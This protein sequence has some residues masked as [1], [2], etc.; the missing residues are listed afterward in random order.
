MEGFAKEVCKRLPLAESVLRL[1][2]FVMEEDFVNDV[3]QRHRGRSYEGVISFPL[4]VNLTADALLQY[5][6]SG[7]RSFRKAQ[8]NEELEASIEAMYGKLRR[9]S[10]TLSEGFFA[11]ATRRL[12]E[13]FPVA[14]NPLPKSLRDLELT[15]IDGKK[16]KHVAKRMK[17]LRTVKGHVLGGKTVVALSLRTNLAVGLAADP[18]GEVSDAPLVP[19]L[20]AQV[21][22]TSD[23][24]RL[25]IADRQFCDLNQPQLFSAEGDHFLIRYNA[26]LKFHRDHKRRI[27]PGQD[28][29][30]RT[31]KEEWGWLGSASDKRRRYVRRITLKRKDAEDV[32][33]ITDLLDDNKY[34]A[35][36]LLRVYLMRWGIER[37]FQRVTE[38][39]HLK[40]L[41]GS[42][43]QATIFQAAFCFLLYNLIQVIRGY[44][45]AAQEI[46]PEDISTE[47]LFEDVKRQLIGWTEMLS[48]A[49]TV[50]L[51]QTTWTPAQVAHRLEVLLRSTW[52]ECWWK[53]PAKRTAPQQHEK[54]YLKGGHD[55]VYRIL[56]KAR[57]TKTAKG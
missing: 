49:D 36:D 9:V 34:P 24:P 35:V 50:A 39:F 31:Y 37:M 28:G 43:P 40:A 14:D 53:A 20:L 29:Q 32:I 11:E 45:A 3:F 15:A 41:I 47:N 18:D 7:H 57:K 46:E 26:K 23:R 22:D 17:A 10:I 16:I 56:R 5:Q 2:D 1:F 55:S 6:G 48:T 38:V 33:L 19:K 12:E 4:M 25:W 30:G 21:R 44:I 42:S 8:E 52:S 27:Q 13:V 54:Q 51:L